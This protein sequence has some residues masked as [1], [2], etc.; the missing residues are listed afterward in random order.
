LGTAKKLKGAQEGRDT[1]FGGH[2]LADE[3]S[4]T[5]CGKFQKQHLAFTSREFRLHK[6]SQTGKL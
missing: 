1:V 2:A 6:M 4:S 3:S 5:A